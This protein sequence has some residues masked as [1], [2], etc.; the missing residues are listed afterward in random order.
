M[1]HLF[2]YLSM[3]VSVLFL[4]TSCDKDKKK[5]DT[6]TDPAAKEISNLDAS[7]YDQ[8]VYFSFETGISEIRSY[9]ESAPEKWDVA[10]HRENVK[11]NEGSAMKT[12]KTS[13]DALTE[14]PVGEYVKDEMTTDKVIVDMSQMMQGKIGYDTTAINMVMNEWVTRSGMPPV[15]KVGENVYVVRTKGGKHAKLQFTS[16]KNDSDKTGF[17]SFSYVYPF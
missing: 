10:F 14:V 4:T 8:W 7:A 1:K 16:Y 2:Y 3:A 15:Y 11:T 5:E 6:G 12:D 9:K 17:V 13:M